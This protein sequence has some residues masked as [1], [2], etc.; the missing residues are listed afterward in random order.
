MSDTKNNRRLCLNVCEKNPIAQS[1]TLFTFLFTWNLGK[2]WKSWVKIKL[3]AE[4]RAVLNL[5]GWTYLEEKFEIILNDL[6]LKLHRNEEVVNKIGGTGSRIHEPMRV[7]KTVDWRARYNYEL[8]KLNKEPTIT[9]VTK[10]LKL[11]LIGHVQRM[12]NLRMPK[13]SFQSTPDES[14]PIGRPR[15]AWRRLH[16]SPHI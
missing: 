3:Q 10:S 11:T 15:H 6:L 16:K 4:P 2:F 8:A 13:I 14:L 7:T 5:Q 12:N 9:N 1:R